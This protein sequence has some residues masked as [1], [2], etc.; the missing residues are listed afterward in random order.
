MQ[1][2]S[3]SL[4]LVSGWMMTSSEYPHHC[5]HCHAEVDKLGL[6]SL[7]CVKSAGGYSQQVIPSIGVLASAKIP[8]TLEPS[9]L[10]RSDANILMESLLPHGGLATHWCGISHVQTPTCFLHSAVYKW[11]WSSCKLSR[12]EY[13]DELKRVIPYPGETLELLSLEIQTCWHQSIASLSTEFSL[14]IKKMP[15]DDIGT[16]WKQFVFEDAMPYIGEFFAMQ[17]KDWYLRLANMKLMAPVIYCLWQL[18]LPESYFT[19]FSRHCNHYTGN[20]STRSICSE[21]LWPNMAIHE[22]HK[23]LINKQCKISMSRVQTNWRLCQ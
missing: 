22:A 23:M 1:P 21:Y 11:S 10:F 2:L 6:H 18:H 17:S 15:D 5:L 3:P 14:F 4:Q 13:G 19:T 9:G 7:S 12:G 16:F 8:S 20:A